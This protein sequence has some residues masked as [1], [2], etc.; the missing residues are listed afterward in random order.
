MKVLITELGLTTMDGKGILPGSVLE[1]KGDVLPPAWNG[2]A[3]AYDGKTLEVASPAKPEKEFQP[4]NE[5]LDRTI[6]Q[7]KEDLPAC[8]VEE[9]TLMIADENAAEKPR[10]GLLQAIEKEIASRKAE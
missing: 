8:N 10:A 6:E 9:L 5:F 4:R 7:I 2:V 3:K 1:V